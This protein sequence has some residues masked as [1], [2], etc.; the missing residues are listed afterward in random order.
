MWFTREIFTQQRNPNKTSEIEFS[1]EYR[2]SVARLNGSAFV[3]LKI[4]RKKSR[5]IRH[6]HRT[7]LKLWKMPAL[8]SAVDKL[9]SHIKGKVVD[10]LLAG[11]SSRDVSGYLSQNGHK[12]SNKAIW[13]YRKGPLR[14]A[15]QAAAK[16]QRIEG[17]PDSTTSQ[18][19]TA[20]SVT[21]AAAMSSV[22]GDKLKD[23]YKRYSSI[24]P[25]L[26]ERE[27]FSD[28]ATW[29]QNETRTMRLDAELSG[30]LQQNPV[31]VAVQVVVGHSVTPCDPSVSQSDDTDVIDLSPSRR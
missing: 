22:L 20:R 13:R 18:L 4:Q 3:R 9:P 7:W 21:Q 29:D 11:D 12:V 31:N 23:K 8:E 5:R 17:I 16:L 14:E 10:M 27:K 26:I 28:A 25:Q 30:L 6:G 19:A 15:L 1:E 2:K 24:I